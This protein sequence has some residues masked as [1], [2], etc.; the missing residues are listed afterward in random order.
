MGVK[1]LIA[2]PCLDMV[3]ADFMQAVVKMQKPDDT[4]LTVVKN[5]L[6]YNGRNLI[7]RKAVK[8]GF[9]RVLWLDSD[10]IA[11]PDTLMRLSEHIDSGVDFV[12]GVY[13]MRRL[14]TKPVVYS[15]LWWK[16]TENEAECGAVNISSV[17]P[18]L[19]EI[20][21]A[22]FGCCMTSGRLLRDLIDRVGAP[23][24]PLMGVSEDLTFCLRARDAGYKLYCDGSIQCGHIGA[25]EYNREMFAPNC[26]K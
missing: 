24:T 1:T 2:V 26:T 23:F 22:G 13:Y 21:G 19:F 15:D 7:A 12:T 6:I 10:V 18:Y 8:H 14:P 5:T 25:I 17:P 20:A 3:Y 11:P 9:D 4:A 16:L